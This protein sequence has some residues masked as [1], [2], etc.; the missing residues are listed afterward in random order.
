MGE[1]IQIDFFACTP[2]GIAANEA[3]ITEQVAFHLP[4][5]RQCIKAGGFFLA[6]RPYRR[7]IEAVGNGEGPSVRA[8]KV[9]DRILDELCPHRYVQD[10][11]RTTLPDASTL[12]EFMP[13]YC[14]GMMTRQFTG[15][16][17]TM[18]SYFSEEADMIMYRMM[19]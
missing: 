4:R 18:T 8:D 14:N 19:F 1:P 15:E 12:L 10:Y 3:W 11:T 7:G 9:F 6:A 17:L 2:E 5:L 13:E 16:T